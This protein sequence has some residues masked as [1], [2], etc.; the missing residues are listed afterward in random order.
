MGNRQPWQAKKIGPVDAK[1]KVQT[2]TWIH[3]ETNN[4]KNSSLVPPVG[5]YSSDGR[6]SLF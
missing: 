6:R 5:G 2:N 3:Y 4:Q 1:A